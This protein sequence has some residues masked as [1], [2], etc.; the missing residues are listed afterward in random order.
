MTEEIVISAGAEVEGQVKSAS[1]HVLG[2]I[3]GDIVAKD[4]AKLGSQSFSKGS[5]DTFRIMIEAGAQYGGT[6][7]MSGTEKSCNGNYT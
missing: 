4:I 6:I 7:S 3:T 1:V 2:R 5:I